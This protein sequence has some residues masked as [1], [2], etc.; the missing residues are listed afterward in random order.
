[1]RRIY[2]DIIKTKFEKVAEMFTH[3]FGKKMINLSK[4]CTKLG[5]V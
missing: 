4:K 2:K 5:A 1:M 3:K